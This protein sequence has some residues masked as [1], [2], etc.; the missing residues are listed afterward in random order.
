MGNTTRMVVGQRIQGGS[1]FGLSLAFPNPIGM[2][3]RQFFQ[4][5][6]FALRGF[7]GTSD[8]TSATVTSSLTRGTN[9]KI[10][11]GQF[12]SAF[13]MGLS[14]IFCPQRFTSHSVLVRG[15][16]FQMDRINT[17]PI[18]TEMVNVPSVR[19]VFHEKVIHNVVG[20]MQWVRLP[21]FDVTKS[22]VTTFIQ[23][24]S[25]FPARFSLVEVFSRNLEFGKQACKQ[26][27]VEFGRVFHWHNIMLTHSNNGGQ[28]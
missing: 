4:S 20:L 23:R 13:T 17:E 11:A 6:V 3:F 26:S 8:H 28:A 24:P 27:A 10:I 14:R 19:N 18:T 5:C 16:S 25:P 22:S 21:L 2:V 15:D 9:V 12:V 1:L 7:C